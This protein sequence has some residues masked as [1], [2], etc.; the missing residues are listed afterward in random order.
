MS[1][2]PCPSS[3]T[4][5]PDQLPPATP[6]IQWFQHAPISTFSAPLP[7]G[8]FYFLLWCSCGCQLSP[9]PRHLSLAAAVCN[10]TAPSSC[11]PFLGVL[12]SSCLCIFACASCAPSVLSPRFAHGRRLPPHGT[13]SEASFLPSL[14]SSSM[15]SPS[16]WVYPS[17]CP[18]T[19]VCP[20]ETCSSGTLAPWI[21]ETVLQVWVGEG[22]DTRLCK[23]GSEVSP[24]GSR[25]WRGWDGLK[26]GAESLP[27]E[28]LLWTRLH[29]APPRQ[30]V[31]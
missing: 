9:L 11:L 4:H 28:E 20:L 27:G 5:L 26:L 13:T 7:G 3:C 23:A 16:H 29:P 10:L 12:C 30:L 8:F 6:Y 18:E 1:L 15:P 25:S 24:G 22:L 14:A 17:G 19:L 21:N 31:C 2:W